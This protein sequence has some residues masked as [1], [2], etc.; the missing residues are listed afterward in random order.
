MIRPL[1]RWGR[2]I[3][4]RPKKKKP[5]EDHSPGASPRDDGDRSGEQGAESSSPDTSVSS[6]PGD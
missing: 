6:R 4:G 5:Q 1:D 3:S 2:P